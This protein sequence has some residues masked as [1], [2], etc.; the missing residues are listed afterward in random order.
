MSSNTFFTSQPP[1]RK[2]DE[3]S[4]S[5][6][7]ARAEQRRND[8]QFIDHVIAYERSHKKRKGIIETLVNWNS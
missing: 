3:M 1:W 8:K 5:E 2:Y 7:I 6:V 4:A